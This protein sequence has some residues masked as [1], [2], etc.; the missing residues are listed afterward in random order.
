VIPLLPLFADWPGTGTPTLNFVSRN[1]QL[2]N[3]SLFD[4]GYNYNCCIAAQS[5]SGKSF[6]TNEIIVS[7]LTEGARI[8]VIDVGRSY[9]NLAETLDGNSWLMDARQGDP[10]AICSQPSGK[11][12]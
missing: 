4:S 9:Q 1:G 5:G 8:W 10:P 6:L 2:I 12:I 11:L 3:V 7:Y